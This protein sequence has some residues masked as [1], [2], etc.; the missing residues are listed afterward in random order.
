MGKIKKGVFLEVKKEFETRMVSLVK[1][2]KTAG[3][4]LCWLVAAVF[5]SAWGQDVGLEALEDKQLK[6]RYL[7]KNQDKKLRPK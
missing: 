2:E 6:M 5:I 7:Y 4:R 3:R 1:W